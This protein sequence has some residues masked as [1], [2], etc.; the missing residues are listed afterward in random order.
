LIEY[1]GKGEFSLPSLCPK[2]AQLAP[3]NGMVAEDINHD[4]F[5]DIIVAGTIMVQK[6]PSGRVFDA[7]IGLGFD[8]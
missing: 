2:L 3:L 5:L 1:K 8:R 7:L 4:G 6:C